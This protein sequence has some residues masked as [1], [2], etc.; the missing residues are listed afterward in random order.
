MKKYFS[1]F[2]ISAL[3]IFSSSLLPVY[4]HAAE[5]NLGATVWCSWWNAYWMNKSEM[6]FV[7]TFKGYPT[8]T[9]G[10]LLSLKI[11]EKW[12]IDANYIYGKF[13]S[14]RSGYVPFTVPIL[15]IPLLISISQD[16]KTERHE[17]DFIISHYIQ[18][19]VKI[20][21]GFKYSGYFI[22]DQIKIIF[23]TM[24]SANDNNYAG[25]VLGATFRIPLVSTLTLDPTITWVMQFGTYQPNTGFLYGIYNSISGISTTALMYYGPEIALSLA[26]KIKQANITL[27]L[28]G[29]FQYLMIKNIGPGGFPGDGSYEMSG[30]VNIMGMYSFNVTSG[31]QE[32]KEKK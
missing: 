18:Q 10:P 32:V 19:Y 9:G 25:P 27:A 8:A 21:V 12:S 22:D 20:F 23:F 28:G 7:P 13:E 4:S 30:G 26:Y 31:A 15:M 3:L 29:R 16:R 17:L 11:N 24:K 5:V 6:P 2:I 1:Y 14:D